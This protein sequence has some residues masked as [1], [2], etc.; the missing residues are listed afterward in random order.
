MAVTVF[1]SPVTADN[2]FVTV[3]DESRRLD[4]VVNE[5]TSAH[6]KVWI[7]CT[8]WDWNC[9]LN[10]RSV[11]LLL[12]ANWVDAGEHWAPLSVITRKANSEWHRLSIC[13]G[14]ASVYFGRHD[15][16]IAG[17][18]LNAWW[19]IFSVLILLCIRSCR[20]GCKWEAFSAPF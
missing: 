16:E 9:L 18:L 15:W 12:N 8:G 13:A 3:T 10:H 4:L 5:K 7:L 6:R 19:H 2:G 14:S 11:H 1:P 17:F 20:G